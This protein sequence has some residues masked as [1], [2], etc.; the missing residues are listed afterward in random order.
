M[1]GFPPMIKSPVRTTAPALSHPPPPDDDNDVRQT[2]EVPGN[3]TRPHPLGVR[4]RDGGVDVAVVAAHAEA[5]EFCL[6]T[7]EPGGP[8]VEHRVELPERTH[9]IWHGFVPD[10][11]PGARYGFRF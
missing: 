2:A 6:L 8:H 7:H 1:G 10:V 11:A 3:P 9:G 5:V 4:P